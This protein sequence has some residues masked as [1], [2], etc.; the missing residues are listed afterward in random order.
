VDLYPAI[1]LLGGEV[2]RLSQGRYDARTVYRADPVEV[3]LEFQDAGAPW[4]HLVDLEAA[5]SGT[6]DQ[7]GVVRAVCAAAGIPVQCGGGVRDL[8]RA[9][10]LLDAGAAR[11]V[12]GTAAVEDAALFSTAAER[13]PGRVAAGI[14][15]RDGE[16][17]VRGWLQGTGR[18]AL[19]VIRAR[20]AAG[21]AAVIV[22][23]IGRDGMLA[24]PDIAGLAA[25]LDAAGGVPVIASGGVGKIGDLQE[26]C[27]LKSPAGY[28]LA[29]AIVG[30]ALYEGVLDLPAA[31]EVCRTV[32][33]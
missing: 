14:D 21:A 24:G 12:M 25:A 5:R 18:Q 11:V 7:N 17:R 31:L 27:A 32:P 10:A 3:A 19:E 20:A 13:W 6:T 1:D 4:I 30:R 9:A 23:D 15:H 26:L 2:V 28:R 16:V 22:T 33:A 29:G 8:D